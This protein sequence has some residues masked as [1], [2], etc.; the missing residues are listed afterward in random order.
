VSDPAE[1][2]LVKILAE[3]D[4]LEGLESESLW[5]ERWSQARRESG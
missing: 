2:H 1:E 5:A 3:L 4:N